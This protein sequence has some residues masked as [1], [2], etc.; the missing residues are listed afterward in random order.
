MSWGW[1]VFCVG[2]VLVAVLIKLVGEAL[3]RE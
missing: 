3:G 1:P 2:L